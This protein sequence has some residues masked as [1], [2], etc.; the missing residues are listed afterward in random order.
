MMKQN[1]TICP[2]LIPIISAIRLHSS[3]TTELS[4]GQVNLDDS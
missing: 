4:Q 2:S 3:L 1:L